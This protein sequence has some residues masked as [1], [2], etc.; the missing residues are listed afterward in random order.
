MPYTFI[1]GGEFDPNAWSNLLENQIIP[2][3]AKQ[4]E[5]EGWASMRRRGETYDSNVQSLLRASEKLAP[6]ED[7][8]GAAEI[9]ATLIAF[10]TLRAQTGRF[11]LDF[12]DPFERYVA[13]V[14]WVCENLGD[15][16]F[17]NCD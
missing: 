7:L 17:W 3:I 13:A 10:V 6:P 5:W 14:D 9:Y 1:G 8:E 2:N 11:P 4:K 16:I 15:I 12:A